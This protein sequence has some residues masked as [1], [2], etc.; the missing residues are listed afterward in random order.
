MRY[1]AP[2]PV[3]TAE[4]VAR[5]WA[6]TT[7]TD[8][9]HILW[10]HIPPSGQWFF[11]TRGRNYTPNRIAWVIANPGCALPPRIFRKPT[12]PH[13][14]CVNMACW[15]VRPDVGA[16]PVLPE[17]PREVRPF[18]DAPVRGDPTP[19]FF[20]THGLAVPPVVEAMAALQFGLPVKPRP[21]AF[22]G[23]DT[24]QVPSLPESE[25]PEVQDAWATTTF[26]ASVDDWNVRTAQC[27]HCD[28][29][30]HVHRVGG[31][32]CPA[33]RTALVE[34]QAPVGTAVMNPTPQDMAAAAASEWNDPVKMLEFIFQPGTCVM[35]FEDHVWLWNRK[36]RVDA[37]DGPRALVAALTL[38]GQRR[39]AG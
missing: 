11:T 37:P 34:V 12:C 38:M 6:L 9:G 25:A 23:R 8:D 29:T 35:T 15:D 3:L 19:A 36:V 7:R 26:R 31:L 39:T 32:H 17:E 14:Y 10:T 30:I 13:K 24:E 28:Q 21:I 33:A 5:F 4:D 18:K 20:G 22:V 1:Q 2:P 27:V 16:G